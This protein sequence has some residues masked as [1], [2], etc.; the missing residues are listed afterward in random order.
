MLEVVAM[1][2]ALV[3]MFACV[4]AKVVTAHLL[5]RMRWSVD[6][7]AQ[8]LQRV[9]RELGSAK[10]QQGSIAMNRSL[11]EHRR[12]KIRKRTA[13]LRAEL[14]SIQQAEVHRRQLL[15]AAR[16]GPAQTAGSDGGSPSA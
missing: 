8:E 11:L 9:H 4:V 2:A 7:V 15:D 3:M 1:S 5:A 13:R 12:D 6:W 10:S 16:G 14:A